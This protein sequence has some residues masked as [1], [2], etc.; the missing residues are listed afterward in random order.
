[1]LGTRFLQCFR[2]K[3]LIKKH[4]YTE[5]K[6]DPKTDLD[7]LCH[8]I[9]ALK[10]SQKN[11]KPK[12]SSNETY[13]QPQHWMR[14]S[15]FYYRKAKYYQ[16]IRFYHTSIICHKKPKILQDAD[17]IDANGCIKNELIQQREAFLK[18]HDM[19]QNKI[20]HENR[21]VYANYH[22]YD[23]GQ[24]DA[25]GNTNLQRMQNGNCPV[26]LDGRDL[27]VIHHLDQ[28][29]DGAWI[30][31]T[32][33]FHQ[34]YHPQLHSN[35]SPI[36]RVKRDLFQEE[37]NFFWKNQAAMHLDLDKENQPMRRYGR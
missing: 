5:S 19:M 2:I 8:R 36:N 4:H 18:K 24:L 20:L 6:I 28:S 23:I 33:S 14:S 1:M 7:D 3:P 32:N 26:G 27:I 13:T 35:I 17:H 30:I 31:L 34:D 16:G 29:H 25:N 37:K 22:L 15:L 12:I 11:T 21:I 9:N 10:L